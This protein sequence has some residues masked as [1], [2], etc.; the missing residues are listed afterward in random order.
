MFYTYGDDLTAK[1]ARENLKKFWYFVNKN[2]KMI[3]VGGGL[4]GLQSVGALEGLVKICANSSPVNI[5][6]DIIHIQKMKKLFRELQSLEVCNPA[7][8]NLHQILADTEMLDSEKS[9]F[10]Q[11]LLF[12][13][14]QLPDFGDLKTTM[15]D[16]FVKVV[17][18][19]YYLR[20]GEFNLLIQALI[21]AFKKGKLS[22]R[23]FQ[24][25]LRML[26]NRGIPID[27]I[28]EAVQ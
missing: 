25:I 1:E 18:A 12:D 28:L 6:G 21:D 11:L 27:E 13:M 3:I 14:D 7:L 8:Q 15:I 5:C 20:L 2:K 4:I 16:C 24:I 22:S 17:T 19:F 23:I 10:V 9:N 26:A